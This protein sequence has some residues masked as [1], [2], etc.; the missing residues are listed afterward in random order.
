MAHVLRIV[1]TGALH[2]M[3]GVTLPVAVQSICVHG[4]NAEAVA[5]ARAVAAALKA[6]GYG[7][8]PLP[9]MAT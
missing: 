6:E 5:T 1:R 3:G 9:A 2:S 8:A 4:D 7:R